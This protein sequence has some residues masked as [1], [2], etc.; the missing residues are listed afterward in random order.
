MS[1]KKL[2]QLPHKTDLALTDLVPVSDT[3][4]GTLKYVTVQELADIIA[5]AQPTLGTPS[6]TAVAD[7]S[8]AIDVTIGSV[9]DAEA[10]IIEYSLDGVSGWTE[11]YNESIPGEFNHT[12]LD[13]DTQYFYR[14]HVEAAGYNNS[15]YA[16]D[17]A[18]TEAIPQLGTPTLS[19]VANGSDQ[20]DVTIGSVTD[21]ENYIIEFS[22]NG[23]SGWT[24]IYNES[25]AGEFNHTGLD[26][27]TQY[28]YRGYVTASGF[29][30]SEYATDD[31]TT[32]SAELITSNRVAE[33]MI[34]ENS[35]QMLFNEVGGN[36][37]NNNIIYFGEQH[38]G[39]VSNYFSAGSYFIKSDT[40][41]TEN[42]AANV[43]SKTQAARIVT[44]AG[45]GEYIGAYRGVRIQGRTFPAGT[46]TL[47]LAVKSNTG[48]SQLMRM[49]CYGTFSSDLTVTT[50]WTRV[51]W[52]F[53]HPGGSPYIYFCINASTGAAMDI[54]IDQLKMETGSS[55]TAY[56]TPKFDFNFGGVLN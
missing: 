30:D 10:Y 52:T 6:L 13:S 12:G 1:D 41:L 55:A 44:G 43:L 33:W 29:V 2:N 39:N 53:T 21:A 42:Y 20:I 49:H 3:S 45:A 54:L 9:T 22:L 11:V 37:A 8:D 38:W 51:S 32:D 4:T 46:Y 16:T 26:S 35:G 56:I 14:G 19:A 40:T 7:G 23:V 28:F 18:T 25:T 47:S 27:D 17:D 24:E 50:S 5:T 34:D 31:A 48:S 36:T 15:E